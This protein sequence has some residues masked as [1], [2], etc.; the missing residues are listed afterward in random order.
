MTMIDTTDFFTEESLDTSW[1]NEIDRIINS[2]DH[3]LREPLEY[4][5]I[6]YLY[7]SKQNCLVD[8]IKEKYV[9]P[10]QSDKTLFRLLPNET[11]LYLIHSKRD[12]MGARYKCVDSFFNVVDIEF[13]QIMGGGMGGGMGV[14]MDSSCDPLLQTSLREVSLLHSVEF[15]PSIFI[16]HSINRLYFIFREMTLVKSSVPVPVPVPLHPILSPLVSKKV[17]VKSTKKV[18]ISPDAILYS[19]RDRT[20]VGSSGNSR[21]K[22][23]KKRD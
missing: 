5:T 14:G 2:Q 21:N 11:L 15:P 7:V 18:R 1:T 20:L 23:S 8:S 12:H 4:I 3:P 10:G 16:F 13:E 6:Q 19:E 17:V 9:F 22:T